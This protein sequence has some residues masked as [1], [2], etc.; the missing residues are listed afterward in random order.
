MFGL[1]QHKTFEVL[2][3]A[4]VPDSNWYSH[5][6]Q[7]IQTPIFGV[8]HKAQGKLKLK[9]TYNK[10]LDTPRTKEEILTKH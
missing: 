6:V 7:D 4:N 2:N 5:Q 3:K 10:R 1:D 9:Q 8:K